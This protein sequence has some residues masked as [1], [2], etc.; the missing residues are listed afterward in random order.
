MGG[1]G[2]SI[3]S[4][5]SQLA[6]LPW[7][8]LNQIRIHFDRNVSMQQ[9]D[10]SVQGANVPN[11]GFAPGG[12]TYDAA[13]FVATWT[14]AAPIGADSVVLHLDENVR[15][16]GTP[17]D[18]E[19]IDGASAFQSGNGT[20]GG[21]F[22]FRINVLPGDVN[23]NQTVTRADLVDVA[24]RAFR[25]AGD[26]QYNPRHDVNADGHISYVDLAAA[27]RSL[28]M[29]LPPAGSPVAAA[30]PASSND[31]LL[32]AARRRSAVDRALVTIADVPDEISRRLPAVAKRMR[33]EATAR[34]RHF[35]RSGP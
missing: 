22:L 23:N 27:V 30:S 24:L 17:L 20:P 28:G 13:N 7:T 19:W 1:E 14:L 2:Y 32:H 16:A 10:L 18:G 15:S 21:D 25:G 6:V 34:N 29:A 12:F 8:N 26:A 35:C 3:P 31:R 4:G 11:Y 33:A 9:N 5:T